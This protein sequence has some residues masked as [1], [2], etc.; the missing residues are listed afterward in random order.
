M[1]DAPSGPRSVGEVLREFL[2][3]RDW[4]QAD[5]AQVI[6]KTTAAINEII[7]GKRS[8]S[9]EI[10]ALFA[11]T[12]G[13]TVE[14]WLT[15]QA[16][17]CVSNEVLTEAKRRALIYELAPIREMARRGWISQTDD[18]NQLEVEL[19]AFFGVE[20]LETAPSLLVAARKSTSYEEMTPSQ[21]AWCFKARNLARDLIT[22]P[23]S[24]SCLG[25]CEAKLRNLLAHATEVSRVPKVL[26]EFGIRFV[27]VQH[28][29]DSKIDGAAMW[30][31]DDQPVIAISLR[32]NRIDSFW[33]TLFHEFIHIKNRDGL[34]VDC[35]LT[36][37]DAMFSGMKPDF[38][39]RADEEAAA[40]LVP[41]EMID[42]FIKRIAPMYS[43]DR[44][45]QFA[46]RIKVHPGIIVGQ[47]QH[48]G[49]VKFSANREMLAQIRHRV[50][51][52]S[53]VD[54]WGSMLA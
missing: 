30:L 12:F 4:S 40:R 3:H 9:P 6:G 38:E 51:P 23:Y 41:P 10:A 48:R 19:R 28:L 11:A 5:L 18:I 21:L 17:S 50:I 31:N 46:H 8:V 47:L 33:F 29:A 54:G 13:T 53:V 22:N 39:R 26:A 20:S 35:N 16:G 37:E 27:I 7:Q 36:G 1:S 15:L 52:T 32:M 14:F 34:S 25:E 42:S 2:H 24:D 49:E 43:K 44:I 45:I